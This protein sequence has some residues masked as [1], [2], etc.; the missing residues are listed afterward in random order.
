MSSCPE[1]ADWDFVLQFVSEPLE[2]DIPNSPEKPVAERTNPVVPTQVPTPPVWLLL[3][4]SSEWM[5]TYIL[6][7]FYSVSG[8]LP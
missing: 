3:T 2:I 6:G 5:F 4:L 7:F 1:N 8:R